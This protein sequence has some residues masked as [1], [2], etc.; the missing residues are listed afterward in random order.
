MRD[1]DRERINKTHRESETARVAAGNLTH[2][3]HN[4]FQ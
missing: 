3:L 4:L 1:I 2:A